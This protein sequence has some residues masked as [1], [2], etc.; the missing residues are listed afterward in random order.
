MKTV[1]A[2]SKPYEAHMLIARLEAS[3][4]PAFA[5]DENMVALDWLASNAIGG[6]K[7]DVAD[8]DY[9]RAVAVVNAPVPTEESE[10]RNSSDARVAEIARGFQRS[11]FFFSLGA[12]PMG[13]LFYFITPAPKWNPDQSLYEPEPLDARPFASAFAGFLGGSLAVVLAKPKE[14][15]RM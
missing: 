15:K 11:V 1:A 2:F 13:A 5:R 3:G 12:L 6:V 10:W 8:E 7:V 14:P 9:E 4:V